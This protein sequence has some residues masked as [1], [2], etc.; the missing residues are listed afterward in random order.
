MPRLPLNTPLQH[1]CAATIRRYERDAV[2][3]SMIFFAAISPLSLF[4]SRYFRY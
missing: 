4:V 2:A 3:S 1:V